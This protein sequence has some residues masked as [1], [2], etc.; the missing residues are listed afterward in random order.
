MFV[1]SGRESWIL[2]CCG[3]EQ[4]LRVKDIMVLERRS[5]YSELSGK[6][7]VEG[8]LGHVNFCDKNA[9]VHLLDD[10]VVVHQAE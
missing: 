5:E 8:F 6:S 3:I 10:C 1:S 2:A 4:H 9:I 7:I